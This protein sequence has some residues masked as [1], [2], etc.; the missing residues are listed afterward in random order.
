MSWIFE[1]DT[2]E[3]EEAICF[4]VEKYDNATPI[5]LH[6]GDY[7]CKQ[8]K[9]YILGVERKELGDFVNAIHTKRIFSQIEKLHEM[10]PVVIIILEG[11]LTELRM[12]FAR[13]HLKFNEG[14]FWETIA[15]IIVRDNFH[16][17]WS[18]SRSETINMAHS[19]SQKMVDGKY[20]SV[21]KWKPKYKNKPYNLLT[22]IPGLSDALAKRLLK[23]YGS[24]HAISALTVNELQSNKGIGPASAK[25]IKKYLHGK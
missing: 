13:I 24:I 18:S 1:V 2:R 10:Y 9:K 15:S 20:K 19:L 17:F 5:K 14:A 16:I 21:R 25:R 4:A 12:K 7:A 23:K 22:E 6:A 3:P 8:G 11:S